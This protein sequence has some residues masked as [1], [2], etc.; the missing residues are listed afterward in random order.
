MDEQRKC[1]RAKKNYFQGEFYS[2]CMEEG[3]RVLK[4]NPC[5]T[6]LVIGIIVWLLQ[7]GPLHFGTFKELILSSFPELTGGQ[8]LKSESWA[9][10]FEIN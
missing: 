8:T 7:R 9:K 6:A 10:C 1:N 4:W 5:I 2:K 3:A